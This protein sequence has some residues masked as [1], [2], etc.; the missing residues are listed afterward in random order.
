MVSVVRRGLLERKLTRHVGCGEPG[1]AT[2]DSRHE[3][4]LRCGVVDSR[5]ISV[6]ADACVFVVSGAS[7]LRPPAASTNGDA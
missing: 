7:L 4:A 6:V 1:I 2:P 5:G 3:S